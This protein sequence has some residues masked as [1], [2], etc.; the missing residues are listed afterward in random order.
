MYSFLTL[1]PVHFSMYCSNCCFLNCIQVSQEGGNVV[2]YSHLFKNFPQFGTYIQYVT[3]LRLASFTQQF[4]GDLSML[5]YVHSLLLLSSSPLYG[6]TTV[7]LSIDL[8]MVIWLLPV[9]GNYEQTLKKYSV[10]SL[11]WIPIFFRVNTQGWDC[12]I[13]M[14]NFMVNFVTNG[15]IICQCIWSHEQYMRVVVSCILINS[16]YCYFLFRCY[17]RYVV[18]SCHCFNLHFP[19][20]NDV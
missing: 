17:N 4:S 5:W 12:C 18:V 6:F 13:I 16:W 9:L 20:A 8:L 1:E 14:I 10:E 11:V 19:M 7:C 15:Q 2:W 3:L